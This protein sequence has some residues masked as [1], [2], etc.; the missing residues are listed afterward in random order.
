MIYTILFFML[1]GL[2][3][4]FYY[5]NGKTMIDAGGD[6]FRQHFK[7]LIYYARHLRRIFSGF[8]S[9]SFEI[10]QW[11]L[12]IGEGSDI[13]HTFHYYC[14]GDI[15][16]FFSFLCPEKYM[17]LY[18][19]G[20]TVLRMY[21]SGFIF[22][23]LCFYKKKDN[24]AAVTAGS[25]L[26]AFCSFSVSAMSGHVF[27]ISA[28]VFL[29]LIILGAEKI[30][31][32]DRPYLLT[33]AVMLSSLSSIYFFYMNVVSTVIFVLIRLL[34]L[35]E[36]VRDR[37]LSL[38]KIGFYSA[39]GL[40]MS[41][42][43]FLPMIKVMFGSSRLD[44]SV[45]ID[46]FFPLSDYLIIYTRMSFEG[47]KYF[48]GFSVL[49]P[50]SFACLF[51]RKRNITLIL[52]LIAV[53][54]FLNLPYLSMVYNAMTYPI[55]RWCY[56]G[57][58]L[59][60]YIIV[61]SLDDSEDYRSLWLVNLVL[62][63]LYYGSC[64]YLD[65]SYRKIHILFLLLSICV[66]LF[67]RFIRDHK[68]CS[69]V[70]LFSV[71][72]GLLFQFYYDFGPSYWGMYRNGT[73]F[74]TIEAIEDDEFSV[75]FDLNDGS[76]YRYSGNDM[77]ENQSVLGDHSST[78]YYWS[79]ANNHIVDFR[80]QLGYSDNSNHHFDN[81]EDRFGQ[82][83]L[84]GIKYYISDSPEDIPYGYEFYQ[85]IRGYDVYTSRYALP[86]IYAYDN[87][88]SVEEWQKLDPAAKNEA[89]LQAAAVDR[90]IGVI[91]SEKVSIRNRD[92]S[93]QM[94]HSD[95][96][97]MDQEHIS[98]TGDDA[99][100]YLDCQSDGSGEYYVLVEGLYSNELSCRIKVRYGDIEKEIKFKGND[101]QHYTDRHDFLVN[102]GYLEGIDGRIS[103]G[104]T[105]SGDYTYR[106]IRVVCQPLVEQMED[107]EHL[108]E[109]TVHDFSVGTNR[110]DA[111]ID[112]PENKIICFAIP[113]AEGW[114]AYIDGKETEVF[115]CN[116][117]YLG[118]EA[119]KGHHQIELE[120]STPLL[121]EGTL[122]G[123][124]SSLVF[125]ALYLKDRISR[126]RKDSS[127]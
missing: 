28:A 92:V 12:V 109:M 119:E 13:I 61:D 48:G 47:A 10:P 67:L 23:L 127:E 22:G 99:Y 82:N 95:Q 86:L 63:I 8:L 117:Q 34:C 79:V 76:V 9:G 33:L 44:S 69:Y 1:A 116:V 66:V 107:I 20:A 14:L 21:I 85:K 60:A 72:A 118:I 41:A 55:E 50:F 102:L 125:A 58:L 17:Y 38:V 103:L 39:L 83:S 104:F 49:W 37:L 42:A 11:D 90:Q 115:S 78:Q 31:C 122:I 45:T 75:F 96:I 70:C 105:D 53:F 81:Y 3:V 111:D 57:S 120:Y 52:L 15:F 73:D 43:I 36:S 54:L 77:D 106:S 5:S 40:L 100:I 84:S 110:I 126:K 18:Y 6:G 68:L 97:L 71:F 112:L 4:F 123:M 32:H 101:N 25:L 91:G 46:P 27:F 26:Y 80:K 89:M 74:E 29:P 56:A 7:A 19:D 59:V 94:S 124:G 62:A 88:I 2:I 16:T 30:I 98:V 114:K 24:L 65:V 87:Y 113:Y 121:K 93:S 35:K 51:F 108:K 64:M